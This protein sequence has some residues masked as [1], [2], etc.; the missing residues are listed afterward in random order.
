MP[1]RGGVWPQVHVQLSIL[2]CAVMFDHCICAPCNRGSYQSNFDSSSLKQH[3]IMF[4]SVQMKSMSWYNGRRKICQ[5]TSC[6]AWHN[7]NNI[8]N[9]LGYF[10]Y[11]RK[12]WVWNQFINLPRGQRYS[13][14][15]PQF[16]AFNSFRR[17]V[18]TI[19]KISLPST[20]DCDHKNH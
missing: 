18:N 11:S 3:G 15:T 9:P 1:T 2:N 12:L 19:V 4:Y 8:W 17:L 13:S 5:P 6:H 16:P 14:S 7:H 10:S 20:K